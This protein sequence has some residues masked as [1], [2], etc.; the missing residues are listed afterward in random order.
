[1]YFALLFDADTKKRPAQLEAERAV[2]RS[3]RDV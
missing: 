2:S 1:M 3:E